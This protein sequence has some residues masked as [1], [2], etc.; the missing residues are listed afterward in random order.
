[1]GTSL[2]HSARSRYTGHRFC[3]QS[4]EFTCT[5]HAH[6]HYAHVRNILPPPLANLGY[7]TDWRYIY[8]Y[9]YTYTSIK[10]KKDAGMTPCQKPLTHPQK[11]RCRE[12]VAEDCCMLSSLPCS[13]FLCQRFL[14]GVITTVYFI[15]NTCFTHFSQ[16]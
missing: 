6:I 2:N 16:P 3:T 11:L 1:M 7:A 14:A 15:L 5:D 4:I 13:A 9:I 8:I 10:I 12:W